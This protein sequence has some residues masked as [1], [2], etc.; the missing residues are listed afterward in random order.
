MLTDTFD[1]DATNQK[2]YRA[3][4]AKKLFSRYPTLVSIEIHERGDGLKGASPRH[5][6]AVYI[7]STGGKWGKSS[8]LRIHRDDKQALTLLSVSN[9]K[10]EKRS[11]TIFYLNQET[12]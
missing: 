1:R 5:G 7:M 4:L 12:K 3:K 2:G 6:I 8:V 10:Q 11:P 9:Q